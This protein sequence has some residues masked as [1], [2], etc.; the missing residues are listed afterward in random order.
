MRFIALV[1]ALCMVAFA[2]AFAQTSAPPD[3]T[4]HRIQLVT[5]EKGVRLEVV[6][7][8]GSGPPLVFLAGGNSTAH[9]FDSFAPR[10]TATHRVLGITRR[11][12][13]ASS[14]PLPVE[15]NYAADR[16]ETMCWR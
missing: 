16:W 10:F 2:A 9:V 5:V 7:W 3:R 15:K 4:K 8:G 11:G 14:V 13:G 6:D 1:I 12:A